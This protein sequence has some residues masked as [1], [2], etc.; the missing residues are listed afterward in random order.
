MNLKISLIVI[1]IITFAL[2]LNVFL[3]FCNFEKNYTNMV[4]SRILVI[5]KDLQN[6]AEYGLGLG[7]S[8]PE[9]RNIQKVIDNIK[10]ENADVE[11]I[12][13]FDG[14]GK[15]LFDTNPKPIM[16]IVPR[17]WVEILNKINIDVSSKLKED[18]KLIVFLPLTNAFN[19][20]VGAVALGYPRSYING[21]VKQMLF[22]LI[23]YFVIILIIFAIIAY[24]FISLFLRNIFRQFVLM[25]S[26][27]DQLFEEKLELQTFPDNGTDLQN[28]LVE[29]EGKAIEAVSEINS[30]SNELNSLLG[31][32]QYG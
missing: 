20:K 21:S 4:N 14:K 26:H 6:T 9:V 7:L 25:Q 11:S 18:D 10:K 15:V 1:S 16:K 5:A 2:L 12:I 22:S 13:I 27:L 30:V 19:A 17:R 28:E 3:N 24:L 8:L 23:R 32:S 29:F 31:E